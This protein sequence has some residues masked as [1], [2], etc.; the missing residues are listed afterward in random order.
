MASFGFV[1]VTNDTVV[2]ICEK[3]EKFEYQVFSHC[4]AYQLPHRFKQEY[5]RPGFYLKYI[6]SNR[7]PF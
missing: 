3:K 6:G 7:A 1:N 2:E 5:S 4:L